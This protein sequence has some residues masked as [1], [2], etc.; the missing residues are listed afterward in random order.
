MRHHAKC[1]LT[2]C[3]SGN[4]EPVLGPAWPQLAGALL[5]FGLRRWC[6]RTCSGLAGHRQVPG[7]PCQSL[8]PPGD[9]IIGKEPPGELID[10]TEETLEAE[11]AEPLIVPVA[12]NDA[13]IQ[14]GEGQ[15]YG[16]VPQLGRAAR[17][18]DEIH[19]GLLFPTARSRVCPANPTGTKSP[20]S[21]R[22]ASADGKRHLAEYVAKPGAQASQ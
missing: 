10:R 7:S 6:L 1:N 14:D 16:R 2:R 19:H 5:F 3:R 15:A 20:G 21:L 9:V 8:A 18:G 13:F 22:A 17:G 4:P 12:G 11:T